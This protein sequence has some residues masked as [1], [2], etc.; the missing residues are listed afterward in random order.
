MGSVAKE[1]YKQEA[2]E[3]CRLLQR[4][5]AEAEARGWTQDRW[6]NSREK[7]IEKIEELCVSEIIRAILKNWIEAGLCGIYIGIA[8]NPPN[9]FLWILHEDPEV[10]Y[11][12][13]YEAANTVAVSGVQFHEHVEACIAKNILEK[14]AELASELRQLKPRSLLK[15]CDTATLERTRFVVEHLSEAQRAA[16]SNLLFHELGGK[17]RSLRMDQEPKMPEHP[18]L[19]QK[20]AWLHWYIWG[21]RM[22]KPERQHMLGGV[23]QVIVVADGDRLLTNKQ[24]G[25]PAD[26]LGP[27]HAPVWRALGR[28][29]NKRG[30]SIKDPESESRI[31]ASIGV[32]R[33][34]VRSYPLLPIKIAPDGKGGVHYEYTMD[35]LLDAIEASSRKKPTK[36][37]DS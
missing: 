23:P 34:K 8:R 20:Q 37:E 29:L 10:I 31:A 12:G 4:L 19:K 3:A 15:L 17:P 2:A 13:I 16:L 1:S 11:E 22:H 7:I 9:T 27:I 6:Y 14:S 36:L 24:T 18:T 26:P 30:H 25:Q 33:G 28:D 5:P 32:S 35:D 21:L